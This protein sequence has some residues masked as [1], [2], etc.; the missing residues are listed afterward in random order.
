[1]DRPP[2]R[3]A[4]GF[5]LA[6]AVVDVM[7]IGITVPVLPT[8]IERFSGSGAAAG[9]IN[10]W[11]VA[12]WAVGQFLAAPV[13]GALSDRFGRRPVLLLSDAG[14]ALDYVLMAVAPNLWWLAAGRL[15][16]GLTSASFTAVYAYVA[17]V[18]GPADRARM[19]GLVGAAFS[20][21]FVAGPALGGWLGEIS[22]T[23][24]FWAA[25]VLAGL[26]FVYGWV[27]LP[28]SLARKNRAAFSW[29]KANPFGAL[30]LVFSRP[31]LPG[32]T[33]VQFLLHAAHFVFFSVFVLFAHYRF[34]WTSSDVGYLLAAVG[35]L[36]I[37]IQAVL[38]GRVV[39][40]L[41]ERRTLVLGL[42]GAT[43]GMAGFGLAPTQ[44][45]F[46]LAVL[47]NALW[48]LAM[49]TLQSMAT[50]LVAENEQ[51]RLQGANMGLA[52]IAGAVASPV[53]GWVFAVSISDASWLP[54]P[55]AAFVLAAGYLLT[56]TLL[57]GPAARRV[58]AAV[59]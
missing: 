28:E 56:A 57:A 9:Q 8:L 14:L 26:T 53:F 37:L 32:L 39:A 15:L 35:A 12:L 51:G 43:V 4:T 42:V 33:A 21:G 38:I 50:R 47:P 25:A 29:A 7:S 18:T 48:G 44:T 41:G 27:V 16:S 40:W 58:P 49:P 34:G 30:G 1:M 3:A 52:S 59:G 31:G 2:P 19:F 24:P 36:D 17:D 20:A 5:I 45:L 10:G 23:A 22:P 13:L 54:H 6:V 11:F 46:A 55:G